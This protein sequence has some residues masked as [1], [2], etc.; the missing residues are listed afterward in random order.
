MTNTNVL[1]EPIIP[2]PYR[3]WFSVWEDLVN[4]PI[5]EWDQK[6][7]LIA[8]WTEDHEPKSSLP[9]FLRGLAKKERDKI[10]KISFQS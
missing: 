4:D 7:D 6:Y 8:D 2:I 3:D 9:L 5:L 10:S 1:T